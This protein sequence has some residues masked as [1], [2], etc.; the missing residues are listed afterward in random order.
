MVCRVVANFGPVG[1]QHRNSVELGPY[2]RTNSVGPS[3]L[4]SRNGE[5]DHW[6][7]CSRK[8][9]SEENVG[10][11]STR[12]RAMPSYGTMK[13]HPRTVNWMTTSTFRVLL[14]DCAIELAVGMLAV[15]VHFAAVV[16]T[17]QYDKLTRND[18][19]VNFGGVVKS[20]VKIAL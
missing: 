5:T 2:W 11:V 14:V 6:T 12:S 13:S 7:G 10:I 19:I 20:F 9:S 4:T 8:A 17:I 16:A 3:W 18:V 15:V 1:V